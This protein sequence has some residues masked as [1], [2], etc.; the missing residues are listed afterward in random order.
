MTDELQRRSF[1]LIGVY[2]TFQLRGERRGLLYARLSFSLPFYH[3]L[4]FP[5]PSH[6]LSL[7]RSLVFLCGTQHP[8][9]LL[10]SF[11]TTLAT[12]EARRRAVDD[13]CKGKRNE[14]GAAGGRRKKERRKKRE[15]ERNL[16]LCPRAR[17]APSEQYA[18]AARNEK[19]DA[20]AVG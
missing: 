1:C 10:V 12:G 14:S 13:T 15:K 2:R 7:A 5:P 8:R 19:V 9:F 16:L 6:F 17:A 4:F 11:L 18:V 20:S 3:P